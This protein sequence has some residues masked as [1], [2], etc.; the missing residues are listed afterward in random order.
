MS[1]INDAL[2]KVQREKGTVYAS[3]TDMVFEGGKKPDARR[4]RL[5]IIIGI[6]VVFIL[7]AVLIAALFWQ[8]MNRE[9]E[10]LVATVA[11]NPPAV[12][13]QPP[14]HEAVA[15]VPADALQETAVASSVAS[16]GVA[17][18]PPEAVQSSPAP[19][20]SE[21]L[22]AEVKSNKPDAAAGGKKEGVSRQAPAD[23]KLLY[24]QALNS[25]REGKL[26]KAEALYQQVIKIDPRH[27]S[28]LNNLGVIW[29]S[30]KRYKQAARS[31]N[32]ALHVRYNYVDAH[33]NLAC[34]S[35]KK[36]DKKQSLF[37]LKN[38][39]GFNPE[40]RQWALQDNDFKILANLPEFSQLIGA[41]G[42]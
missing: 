17:S 42:N 26:R 25:H 38:A 33:Y 16:T 39:I 24:E 12:A 15:D 7:A 11:Q 19:A 36:N 6:G 32:D 4:K 1:Y 3:C 14:L 37:H 5:P 40:V 30:Q 18:G 34:L 28:A 35:A 10:T 22:P 41:E 21:S 8:E 31:F 2:R 27:V 9:S 23:P 20:G 29:M 13:V